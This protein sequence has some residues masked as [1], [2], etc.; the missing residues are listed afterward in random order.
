MDFSKIKDLYIGGL[1]A[2]AAYLNGNKIWTR[3]NVNVQS[4]L[5]SMVLWY[6]LKRQGATNGNM[7]ATKALRDLSGNGHDATCYNFAW[8]EESGINTTNYPNALVSDGVD[9]Y[10]YTD[11]LPI[12]TDYTVIAKRKWLGF[13]G[14]CAVASK[15]KNDGLL[16]GAF[17]LE[18]IGSG[19]IKEY[20]NFGTNNLNVLFPEEITY[21][22][23]ALYNGVPVERGSASDNEVLSLFSTRENTQTRGQIA[24][25]SFLLFDRTLTTAEINWVKDNMVEYK[26]VTEE[27]YG[28]EFYTTSPYPDC[29]RIGNMEL[30]KTLPVHIQMKGCLLS[31]D[32]VVNKYLNETDWTSETRD[33]SQGQVM[34]EMPKESYWKFETEG[35]IRRVKFSTK[36][37]PGFTKTPQGYVSAYE[38]TVQRGVNK[39]ASVVNTTSEYRG[40]NNQADRDGTYRSVLGMPA[41]SISRINF[42]N[43]ARNRKT[44]STEWNCYVY[45]M[46]KLLYW[47]FV[48]EYATLNSQKTFNPDKDSN[49]YAQGGLG[50]GVTNIDYAKWT[51][52]NNNFPFVSCG[53][54]DILGNGTGQIAFTM[55]NEYEANGEANYAGEYSSDTS[56]TNGQ[57]ITQGENLYECIADAGAGTAITDT[58]HFTK[59]N[60]TVTNVI[61]Y[62]GIENPFGHIWQWTDGIN[63]QI[64]SGDGLSKVFVCND[65]SKFNDSNYDGYQH[66]GNEARTEAYVKSVIFGEGGEIMP[67]VVGGSS[68]TYFCDYHY[69]NIPSAVALR[70]V[71]FGGDAHYGAYAGFGCAYSNSTPSISAAYF[72]S[73]LC[74][75]PNNA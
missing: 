21:G 48:V 60:R 2:Q 66:V 7:A 3:E 41:T 14:N 35:N 5:D 11:G 67:D 52:F 16:T 1:P 63:V 25:Y 20:W 44:D 39:L 58:T 34:V 62:R 24:L 30:H 17:C 61:R 70:G 23:P 56:Y 64:E 51:A 43:Y 55:P 53:Y 69:T 8:T 37:L 45:D 19:N 26:D 27:W 50:N 71:L 29:I 68:S 15:F 72:G 75:I 31:D 18:H 74:F 38:A 4:I 46:H 22:T 9:D 10:C 65:P 12:L 57:W 33:G 54:T 13:A 40:G 36:P 28:V 47:L 59:R 73:R 42:R 49:G 6:D 32:G